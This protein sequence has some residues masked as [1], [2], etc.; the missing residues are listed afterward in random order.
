VRTPDVFTIERG[1]ILLP[2][3]PGLGLDI[4]ED[5]LKEYRVHAYQLFA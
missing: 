4:N 3:L 2:D 5:A 1:Y